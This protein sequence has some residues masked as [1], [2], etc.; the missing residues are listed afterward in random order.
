MRAAAILLGALVFALPAGATNLSFG[1][2]VSSNAIVTV[3]DYSVTA[4]P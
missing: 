3:D 4:L 2:S 1:I